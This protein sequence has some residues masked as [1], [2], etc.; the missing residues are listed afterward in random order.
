MKSIVDLFDKLEAGQLEMSSLAHLV[1]QLHKN[2]LGEPRRRRGAPP[3]IRGRARLR[4][5]ES[6]YQN[7]YPE[8]ICKSPKVQAGITRRRLFGFEPHFLT[9]PGFNICKGAHNDLSTLAPSM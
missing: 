3:G 9:L 2:R 5:E 1:K 6:F 4:L 7:P 8:C